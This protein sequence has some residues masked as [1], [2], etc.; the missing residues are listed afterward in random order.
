M[1]NIAILVAVIEII[2]VI[3]NRKK[4]VALY[5]AVKN[6]KNAE[7]SVR[8]ITESDIPPH[9]LARLK[10]KQALIEKQQKGEVA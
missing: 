5:K 3:Y 7:R 1:E 6:R 2:V 9:I 8:K 4:F 10:A